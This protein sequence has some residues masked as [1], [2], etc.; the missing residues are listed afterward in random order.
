MFDKVS[1]PGVLYKAERYELHG[2]LLAWLRSY[3]TNRML[4][5]AVSGQSSSA[6]PVITGILQGSILG[7]TLFLL[8][9]NDAED[10][11]PAGAQLAAYADDTTLYKCISTYTAVP[12]DVIIL[13]LVGYALADWGMARHI[14]F[15]PTKSQSLLISH[16][17]N[18]DC[19]PVHSCSGSR[20][21]EAAGCAV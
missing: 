12:E 21:A 11:L 14:R 4:Q 18:T 7:P 6:Y 10:H 17:C 8:Y 3:L 20:P 2:H 16:P 19:I 1:H 15:E 9:T 13:Q 5:A